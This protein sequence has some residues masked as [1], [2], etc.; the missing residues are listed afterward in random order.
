MASILLE[1]ERGS[2]WIGIKYPDLI[3]WYLKNPTDSSKF[4]CHTEVRGAL[5][6]GV[7]LHMTDDLREVDLTVIGD[8]LR[9]FTDKKL[10]ELPEGDDRAKIIVRARVFNM[11]HNKKLMIDHVNKVKLSEELRKQAAEIKQTIRKTKTKEDSVRKVLA[12][13]VSRNIEVP[14]ALAPVDSASRTVETVPALAAPAPATVQTVSVPTMVQKIEAM[15]ADNQLK[16]T[17][18]VF[19][20]LSGKK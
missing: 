10:K 2:I 16:F 3:V 8:K 9:S 6:Y 1:E 15:T 5:V 14:V 4:V 13:K 7:Q 19:D 17:D 12:K 11:M 18:S 20:K